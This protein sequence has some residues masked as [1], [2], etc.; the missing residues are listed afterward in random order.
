MD[1]FR[2]DVCQGST[3]HLHHLDE[4]HDAYHALIDVPVRREMGL[5]EGDRV[6]ED[7]EVLAL[8][9]LAPTLDILLQDGHVAVR[10]GNVP[11]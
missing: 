2:L 3:V 9:G 4:R 1:F 5:A 11:V 7:V 8:D 10:G 6:L